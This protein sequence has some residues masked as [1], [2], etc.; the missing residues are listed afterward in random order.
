LI[1]AD[2]EVTL[3]AVPVVTVGA[4]G[5]A[6]VKAAVAVVL[7]SVIVS[8]A[9]DDPVVSTT[10]ADVSEVTDGV[11]M[12]EPVPP[13]TLNRPA[14]VSCVQTVLEPVMVKVGVVLVFPA[15]GEMASVAVATEIVVLIESVVSVMTRAPVPVPVVI[16]R[17]SA[18]AEV[19]ECPVKAAPVTP[20]TL[21]AVLPLHEVPDPAKVTVML[22]LWLAGI[23]DGVALKEAVPETNW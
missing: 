21:K 19:L 5:V 7:V 10:V 17:V 20:E 9:V 12:L 3:L 8:V 13:L 11:P 15:L 1:T 16:V 2:D 22:L 23:T 6:T 18:V 4:V 14:G